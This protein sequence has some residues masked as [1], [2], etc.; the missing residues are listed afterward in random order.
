M[1]IDGSQPVQLTFFDSAMTASPA[2]SPN[3]RRIAFV[4]DQ[5]GTPKVWV[6]NADGGTANPLDK[7]NASNTNNGLA[8]FPSPEIVYQQPGLHNLRLLNVETQEETPVLPTDSEGWL[9]TRPKFSPDG[10]KFAILWN[11]PS[12]QG[13]WIVTLGKY[14]EQLLS[15]NPYWALGW[16]P[17]GNSI[18]AGQ[19]GERKIVQIELEDSK[20][21]KIVITLRGVLQSGSVSPDGRKLIVIEVEEKSDVWLLNNFDSQ[22]GP[23]K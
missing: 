8:W 9:V 4:C 16:S 11:R 20:K 15:P 1:P 7:T 21:P 12:A 6:V 19:W 23:R 18:Y 13:L 17:D 22:V 10:K 3:G 2:W 14:S 5:G